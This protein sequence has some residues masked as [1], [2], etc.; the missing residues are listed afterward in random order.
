M[1]FQQ[2]LKK[3]IGND[4]YAKLEKEA[5]NEVSL[6]LKM[7]LKYEDGRDRYYQ[8][9]DLIPLMI[10]ECELFEQKDLTVSPADI[11]NV[12]FRCKLLC[13]V[14]TTEAEYLQ[15]VGASLM[16]EYRFAI[17]WAKKSDGINSLVDEYLDKLESLQ[18]ERTLIAEINSFDSNPAGLQVFFDQLFEKLDFPF[19]CYIDEA[20]LIEKHKKLESGLREYNSAE[21]KKYFCAPS[22]GFTTFGSSTYCFW[23]ASVWLRTFLC[24]LKISG[25]LNPGQM[26]FGQSGVE[27]MP[28]TYPVF[29]G[30]HSH[31]C[32]CWEEDKKELWEKVPDGCLFRSF[33]YRGISTMKLDQ[34][35][36]G[37]IEKFFLEYKKILD[38]L[39][40]PWDKR[41]LDD[42]APALDI[43][44]SAIQMPDLGA[45]VLLIYCCLEHLFVPKNMRTDNKKYI[46]GGINALRS[47][48][49]EWF[50]RLYRLRCDYAHKGFIQKDDAVLK[51]IKESVRNVMKLL[52]AK[53]YNP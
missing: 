20:Q 8:P 37:G 17:P 5:D 42:I 39:K 26:D 16:D 12:L 40:N 35:T 51:L 25:F 22:I 34:R 46:V 4:I 49:L 28:P 50:N 2:R 44:S 36:Y 33:G 41:Y 53:F 31:G 21:A 6:A 15:R 10:S 30:T 29:L 27:I 9:R 19:S 43:L 7:P 48:L 1:T 23:Y 18:K 32:Y 13:A 14:K 45:K 3:R 52:L 38:L 24:L 11:K 47:D